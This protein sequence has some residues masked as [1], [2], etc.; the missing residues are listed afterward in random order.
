M[1]NIILSSIVY[2]HCHTVLC[3]YVMPSS[4][5]HFYCVNIRLFVNNTFCVQTE[6]I[7][8]FLQLVNKT[9][10]CLNYIA[11]VSIAKIDQQFFCSVVVDIWVGNIDWKCSEIIYVLAEHTYHSVVFEFFLN[12]IKIFIFIEQ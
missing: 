2:F 5:T 12:I 7:N 1:K 8:I 4:H 9:A 6:N 11:F 10:D 3:M